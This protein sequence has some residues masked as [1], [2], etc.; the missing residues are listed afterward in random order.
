[1]RLF[2]LTFCRSDFFH[3]HVELLLARYSVISRNTSSEKTVF[4]FPNS[5][6]VA[7]P[8]I[9]KCDLPLDDPTN[10]HPTDCEWR[11]LKTATC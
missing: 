7:S 9:S 5:P 4:A 8:Q 11:Y 6:P 1:M 3:L 2:Y 10:D